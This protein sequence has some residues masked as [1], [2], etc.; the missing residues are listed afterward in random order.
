MIYQAGKGEI[1]LTAKEEKASEAP[2]FVLE[3][4]EP[5][6]EYQVTVWSASE[7]KEFHKSVTVRTPEK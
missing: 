4:L 7:G 5:G 1:G 6:T 3:K 2:S